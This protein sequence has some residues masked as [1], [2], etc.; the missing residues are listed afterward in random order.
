ML[1]VF[2]FQALLRVHAIAAVLQIALEH[3]LDVLV[4][5]DQ[6]AF[7]LLPDE[8]QTRIDEPVLLT[9]HHDVC[10]HHVDLQSANRLPLLPDE[11]LSIGGH[12][13]S[14]AIAALP[15]ALH[16]HKVHAGQSEVDEELHDVGDVRLVHVAAAAE[17]FALLDQLEGQ[18]DGS[19]VQEADTQKLL[20]VLVVAVEISG[21]NQLDRVDLDVGFGLL[22][23]GRV[24][25]V[26]Q[27]VQF[28]GQTVDRVLGEGG[29]FHGQVRKE[30]MN[31][32]TAFVTF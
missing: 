5:L 20:G 9:H 10:R 12:L 17:Q 7:L 32:G 29:P 1:Q 21:L 3:A 31:V 28:A 16:A 30:S 18:L 26:Q 19:R 8:H 4:R 24:R 15:V 23:P 22:V 13:L 6:T 11:V 25:F 27:S 2:E 14:V